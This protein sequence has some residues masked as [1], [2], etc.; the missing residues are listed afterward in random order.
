MCLS[1]LSHA[2]PSTNRCL[3]GLIRHALNTCNPPR[4]LQ[5]WLHYYY[6]RC[7][8]VTHLFVLYLQRPFALLCFPRLAP[9]DTRLSNLHA[10][11]TWPDC[12]ERNLSLSAFRFCVAHRFSRRS[13]TL[14]EDVWSPFRPMV[15]PQVVHQGFTYSKCMLSLLLIRISFFF[16][17]VSFP[18][19]TECWPN[20]ISM[21][22]FNR[23]WL[24]RPRLERI[25]CST[26]KTVCSYA[27][28]LPW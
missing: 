19:Q 13:I 15:H 21:M 26:C 7:L 3:Q 24:V 6:N 1:H 9:L 25:R 12:R 27:R 2:L 4:R 11:C 8:S 5:S 20:K 10:L 17:A 28:M 18:C 16:L 23:L 14:S 22:W